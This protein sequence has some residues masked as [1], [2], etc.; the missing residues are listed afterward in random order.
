MEVRGLVIPGLGHAPSPV[1][2]GLMRMGAWH[3][4]QTVL[5]RRRAHAVFVTFQKNGSGPLTMPL[6]F[7]R[8]AWYVRKN[9]VGA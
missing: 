6:T 9:P 5:A 7:L 8:Q 2:L 4:S 3:R 1:L